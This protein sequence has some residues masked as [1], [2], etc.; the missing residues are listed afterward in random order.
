M[1]TIA[2]VFQRLTELVGENQHP[3]DQKPKSQEFET[4]DGTDPEKLQQ[5]LGLLKLNFEA[6]PH[7][8]TTDVQHINYALLCL[9]SSAL[10][11]FKPN[12]LSQ[13][14]VATWMANFEEFESN[15]HANFGTFNQVM[16]T[17]D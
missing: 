1:L 3:A 7:T 13:N 17:E 12:I 5:F 6:C 11:W 10:E 4:F 16:D 2:T 15:L 8:F 14:P 9:W